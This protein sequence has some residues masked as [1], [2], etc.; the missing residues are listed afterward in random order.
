MSTEHHAPLSKREIEQIARDEASG[1][2]VRDRHTDISERA[3]EQYHEAIRENAPYL[4]LGMQMALTI[5][6]GA[7]IGWWIDSRTGSSLWL[8]LGAGIGAVL[9]MGY[10]ILVVLKMDRSTIRK[11]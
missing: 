6:L 7:A 11:H 5:A 8:G 3:E 4:T 1:K 10:F 2:P 9:G